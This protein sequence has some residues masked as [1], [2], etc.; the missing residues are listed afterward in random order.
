MA[1]SKVKEQE[2]VLLVDG[3]GR[4]KESFEQLSLL[5]QGLQRTSSLTILYS[6]LKQDRNTFMVT[7]L[8][9]Y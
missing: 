3:R 9:G 1:K 4:I 6:D 5:P 8:Q 2:T 7:I